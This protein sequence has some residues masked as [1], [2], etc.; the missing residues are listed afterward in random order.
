MVHTPKFCTGNPNYQPHAR[1][2]IPTLVG[3]NSALEEMISHHFDSRHF[4]VSAKIRNLPYVRPTKERLSHPHYPNPEVSN[5]TPNHSEPLIINVC[6]PA[7]SSVCQCLL[8]SLIFSLTPVNFESGDL[9]D[10]MYQ[11]I[12]FIEFVRQAESIRP[13][14]TAEARMSTIPPTSPRLQSAQ[15]RQNYWELSHRPTTTPP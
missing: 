13:L 11:Q 15:F 4:N 6:I 1:D 12:Y 14:Y 9:T 2:P 3:S 10:D 5:Q 7:D 8:P